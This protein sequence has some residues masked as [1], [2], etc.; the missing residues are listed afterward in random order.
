MEEKVF[1]LIIIG[2]G[3]G[4]YHLAEQA[5]KQGKN[6][7]I[8][9]KDKFGG[10]CVNVG[11]IPSKAFLHV[12]QVVTEAN[13]SAHMGIVT[14]DKVT[15]DQKQVVAFKNEKVAFLSAGAKAGVKK[16]G[17]HIYEGYGTILKTNQQGEFRVQVNKEILIGKHLIIAT[18]SN[19]FV[20][21]IEGV[22]EAYEAGTAVTSTEALSL[23]EIPKEL[24]VIGAGV[25][26]LELGSYFAGVGSKVTIVELGKKIAGATD[27]EIS[28]SLKKALEN[29]GI[30][31]LL[32]SSV[33]AI[34]HD[35]CVIIDQDKKENKISFTKV[36]V[37]A[38]RKPYI[39]N[40]GLEN[41]N[42]FVERGAIVTDEHLKT[43]VPGVYAI[44]DVNGKLMLAHTAFREADVVLDNL[45]G[46]NTEINYDKIP[47]VIYGTPEVAE[48]GITEDKAKE[49]NI[50]VEIKKMSMLY[51]GRF[52]IEE[53]KFDGLIKVIIKK[54]SEEI[55]GMSIFGSYASEII[56]AGSI[57]VGKRFSKDQLKEVVFAHPTVAE[58]IKD[59]VF[60]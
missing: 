46:K 14:K 18:G 48:I 45:N 5:A 32:N 36:L 20:P 4:G 10:T 59:C 9:E 34:N 57:L 29:K 15:I 13:E 43:N 8:I 60:S 47:V 22:R 35:Y 42:L 51:S 31:F 54:D 28:A 30:T 39:A 41:I 23:E 38:G 19:V 40:L 50:N 26:G 27:T 1:D 12:E 55:I 25:I 17:A 49:Q 33:K 56:V 58:I 24:V 44:G 2:G 6:V 52:V 11:C 7:A 53:A 37:A 16:S 3:P 21:P